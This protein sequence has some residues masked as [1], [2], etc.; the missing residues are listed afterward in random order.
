M[1]DTFIKI[2]CIYSKKTTM[3]RPSSKK[4]SVNN[5]SII[6]NNN[7][8]ISIFILTI[9]LFERFLS[10]MDSLNDDN[11][12]IA[13]SCMNLVIKMYLDSNIKLKYGS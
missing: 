6:V 13:I 7:I 10:N 5:C 12:L 2:N 9:D 11:Q 1:I 4:W 3:T 8:G